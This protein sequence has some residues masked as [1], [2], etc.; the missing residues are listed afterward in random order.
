F[1]GQGDLVGFD[2][3]MAY[4]L[5]TELGLEIEF[6]PVPRERLAEVINAGLYD[7]VM[8]GIAVTS[9]RAAGMVFSPPYI[10]ETLSFVVL[11]HRRADFSS[12]EWVR[13]TPGLRVAVPDLP[14]FE[15]IVHRE[16]PRVE[17]V[18]VSVA[19]VTD[20]FSGRGERVDALVFPAERGSYYTLLYP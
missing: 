1:N 3:E 16:F 19:R 10:D 4:A 15:E 5:A 9:R 7:V 20:F 18:P 6:V 14:Y 2:I 12:A 8:G 13:A 11:D 17:I